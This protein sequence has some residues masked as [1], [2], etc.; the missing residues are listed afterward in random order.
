LVGKEFKLVDRLA[1]RVHHFIVGWVIDVE[2]VRVDAYDGAY[3]SE[4]EEK[5]IG[6]EWDIPYFLCM[7][8]ISKVNCPPPFFTVSKYVS[9]HCVAAAIL[10]PGNLASG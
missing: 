2:F 9:Y 3:M 7:R 6:I 4:S 5:T 1:V 8:F 10:G